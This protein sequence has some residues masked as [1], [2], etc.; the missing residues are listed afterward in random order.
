[1]LNFSYAVSC[2]NVVIEAMACGFPVI[3]PM[4][5]RIVEL[6]KVKKLLVKE[7]LEEYSSDTGYH[8]SLSMVP[9]KL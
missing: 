4:H 9:V 5:G 6:V 1:M 2:P 7:S 3:A 8:I